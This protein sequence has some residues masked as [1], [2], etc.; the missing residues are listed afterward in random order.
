MMLEQETAVD[1]NYV[2]KN[3]RLHRDGTLTGHDRY[4]IRQH[5]SECP[6]CR[7]YFEELL[8][9]ANL[10]ENLP[11]PIPQDGLL[12][13]INLTLQSYQPFSLLDWISSPVSRIFSALNLRLR[14]VFVNFS[15]FLLYAIIGLFTAKMIFLFN[16]SDSPHP[17]QPIVRP[18]QKIVTLAEIKKSALSGV[19]LDV[20]DNQ[21]RQPDKLNIRNDLENDKNK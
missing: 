9:T 5:I 15:A 1:C 21:R 8:Y 18:R 14:P 6:N 3:L 4:F 17:T 10:L 19:I 13:R 12:E 2:R 7:R 16:G 11:S 20:G